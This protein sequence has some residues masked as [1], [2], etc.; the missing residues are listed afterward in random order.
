M[1]MCHRLSGESSTDSPGGEEV[2]DVVNDAFMDL[3][4]DEEEEIAK[5]KNMEPF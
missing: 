2:H 3:V 1:A 5:T 4:L